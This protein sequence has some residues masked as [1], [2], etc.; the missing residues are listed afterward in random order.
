MASTRRQYH[1]GQRLPDAMVLVTIDSYEGTF[2]STLN[3]DILVV[4]TKSDGCACVYSAIDGSELGRSSHV[5]VP[6]F[7]A[8]FPWGSIAMSWH[9]DADAWMES[10]SVRMPATT[11]IYQ[12][13]T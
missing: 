12:A 6:S 9:G 2:V 10:R 1:R 3:R 4:N 5:A 7:T 13:T 8:Q 11:P